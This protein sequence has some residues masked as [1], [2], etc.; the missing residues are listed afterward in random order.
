MKSYAHIMKAL[1]DADGADEQEV[2]IDA[3]LERLMED[4]DCEA[5]AVIDWLCYQ[6]ES[7]GR[8]VERLSK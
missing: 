6:L 2:I 7:L 3:V 8:T 1:D 5:A 4:V